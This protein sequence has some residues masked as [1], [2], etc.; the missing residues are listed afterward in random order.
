MDRRADA[1][2]WQEGPVLGRRQL[3]GGHG[4][5]MG[6]LGHAALEVGLLFF[7]RAE[8]FH[9]MRALQGKN[10]SCGN[11]LGQRS[12][13]PCLQDFWLVKQFTMRL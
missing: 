12:C 3:R 1:G 8:H 9:V 6:K 5:R 4:R 2:L 7:D 11:F 13:P 10:C